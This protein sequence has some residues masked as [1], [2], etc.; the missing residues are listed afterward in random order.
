VVSQRLLPRQDGKGR[1]L[2]VEIMVNTLSIAE[3]IKE[4]DKTL[5]MKEFIEKGFDQYGMQSF[6]QS[7]TSL[8]KS[9]VVSLE[10]AKSAASNPAD[11]ERA[12]NFE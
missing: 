6:D 7:L 10:V 5:N 8:F 1:A 9:G 4:A 12:L 11:F 3:C 2:A